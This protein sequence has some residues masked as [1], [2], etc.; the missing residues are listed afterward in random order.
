MDHL[1]FHVKPPL[2]FGNPVQTVLCLLC[3]RNVPQSC[4]SCDLGVATRNLVTEA[5]AKIL[6]VGQCAD[7]K[8]TVR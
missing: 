2:L 1:V 6:E 8:T 3:C 4:C 5:L 7:L